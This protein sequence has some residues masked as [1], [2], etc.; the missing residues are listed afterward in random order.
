MEIHD[1]CCCAVHELNILSTYS[2]PK[3]AML[4]FC[5]L[6][7][8]RYGYNGVTKGGLYTPG[9][10]YIF[11]GVVK[12]RDDSDDY[13]EDTSYGLNFAAYIKEQRLGVVSS[14]CRR[15]NRVNHPDHTIK[16]WI[17]APSVKRLRL[18]WEA[19]KGA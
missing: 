4:A 15:V 18:W 1:L 13:G 8:S 19:N 5:K 16:V 11:T 17:W 7:V 9:A 14:S 10:F 3:E 12:F 6:H 2:T